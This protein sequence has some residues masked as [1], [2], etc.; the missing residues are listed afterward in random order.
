M[1][2]FQ[3]SGSAIH[4]FKESFHRKPLNPSLNM[5]SIRENFFQCLLSVFHLILI[6]LHVKFF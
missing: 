3:T 6:N 5:Y 2:G 4:I 1:S